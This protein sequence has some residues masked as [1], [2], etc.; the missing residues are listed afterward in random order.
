MSSQIKELTPELVKKLQGE[1]LVY[2]VT[3]CA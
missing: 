2:V 3:V 1:K